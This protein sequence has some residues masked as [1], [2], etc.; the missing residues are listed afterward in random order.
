MQK[1]TMKCDFNR[2]EHV[3]TWNG[4]EDSYYYVIHRYQILLHMQKKNGMGCRRLR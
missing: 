3:Y 2:P 1:L 4:I